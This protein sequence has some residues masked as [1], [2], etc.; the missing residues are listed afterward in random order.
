MTLVVARILG[1]RIAIAADTLLTEH[2]SPLPFQSGVIKSCMLPGDICVSF[3]NSPEL[4]EIA[5]SRFVQR[6][7]RGA[8]FSEVLSYFEDSSR[9][10]GNDYLIAF[11][12]PARLVT[13]RDGRRIT[14]ISKTTWIGDK[15]AYEMFREYE[16]RKRQKPQQGRAINA[17][18]FAD[19]LSISPASDLFSTMRN[20]T[21]DRSLRSV[22]GFVSVISNR[23]NGFRFSAYCD[24]LFD[25]PDGED[26]EYEI[27]YTD[28]RSLQTSGENEG[29]SVAQI[30]PGFM[31]L[32]SVAFYF[33]KSKTLFLFFGTSYGLAN[34]CKVFQNVNASDIPTTLNDFM[35]QDMR[36][37]LLVTGPRNG[38]SHVGETNTIKTPGVQL[39]FMVHANTFSTIR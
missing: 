20:L 17:A 33:V 3:N 8:S 22:G 5:F 7:P 32:N 36:W 35:G 31:G 29:Y 26:D 16:S 28:R 38:G 39:A 10:S 14:S 11:N 18:L 24:M 37:L 23:D 13:I 6:Y 4:S 9:E 21:L 19:E 15:E 1:Q 34:R 27:A 25:W 12:N 2:D 30:S